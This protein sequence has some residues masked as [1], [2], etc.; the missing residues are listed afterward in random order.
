MTAALEELSQQASRY[1][2]NLNGLVELDKSK[3][4]SGYSALV[5]RGVL[6]RSGRETLVAVKIF[7]SAQAVDMLK[8]IL[9]E[10]HLSSKLDHENVNPLL[11]ISTEFDLTISIISPW[12]ENGDAYHYVQN[13]ENDPRPLFID[14]V[15]GLHYLHT[16][17]SGAIFHG[18][19]K[20][21]PTAVVEHVC[22]LQDTLG[23]PDHDA[24]EGRIRQLAELLSRQRCGLSDEP[25]LPSEHAPAL[26][27]APGGPFVL[28]MAK[29]GT[30]QL[31][32]INE[33]MSP[34][35]SD[36]PSTRELDSITLFNGPSGA[37]LQQ[38][39]PVHSA[40]GKFA[41]AFKRNTTANDLS[42]PDNI[43][44]RWK[45]ILPLRGGWLRTNSGQD[46]RFGSSCI[47]AQAMASSTSLAPTNYT[48]AK[49]FPFPRAEGPTDKPLGWDGSRVG[50]SN[51]MTGRVTSDYNMDFDLRQENEHNR[52]ERLR[53]T[54][55]LPIIPSASASSMA[56]SPAPLAPPST[57]SPTPILHMSPSQSDDSKRSHLH[58]IKNLRIL[59][60]LGMSILRIPSNESSRSQSTIKK[61][62]V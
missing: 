42:G 12:R 19:L 15:T 55:P 37:S 11:G 49:L 38:E 57:P 27:L 46:T 61:F 16:H 33:S 60:P 23:S 1:C 62:R 56:Q 13:V 36:Q 31:S 18:D 53:P 40:Q 5:Y 4:S 26:P 3:V 44:P 21:H 34:V 28:S 52:V 24:Y 10:V 8:R 51:T 39:S 43:T 50:T 45:S 9:R 35:R 14:I 32:C 17:V 47:S 54:S 7:R 20:G 29:V 6:R 25:K 22:I 41:R 58:A 30:S 2:I 59:P 48:N